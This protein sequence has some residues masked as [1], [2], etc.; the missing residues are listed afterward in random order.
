[1]TKPEKD[2]KPVKPV[3]KPAPMSGG[4]PKPPPEDGG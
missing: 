4:T 3:E 2:K 1:M